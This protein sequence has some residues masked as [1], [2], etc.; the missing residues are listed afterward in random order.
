MSAVRVA[1]DVT[2]AAGVLAQLVCCLGVVWMRDVFDR[3]HF[4][5]A[6]T[7]VGPVLI[8]VSVALT[9]FSSPSGTVQSLVALAF[10]VLLGP[11]LT[12]ATG[13]AARNLLHGDLGPTGHKPDGGSRPPEPKPAPAA[14]EEG[15]G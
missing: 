8:G 12:H 11:V 5:G 9:G 10:L 3:L 7:T 13:R 15:G 14:P 6:G 1:A 4:A 2:L